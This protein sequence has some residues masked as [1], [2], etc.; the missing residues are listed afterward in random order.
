VLSV[1]LAAP[2]A[3]QAVSLPAKYRGKRI[4]GVKT[5]QKVVAFDFNDGPINANIEGS[6]LNLAQL[7]PW[8]PPSAALEVPFG[9]RLGFTVVASGQTRHPDLMASVDVVNPSYAGVQFDVLSV[10]IATVREGQIDVDTLVIKRGEQQI[11]VDG[12]LPFSWSLPRENGAASERRPGLIPTGQ[13]TLNGRI[14][15]TELAFFL[16]L[17][18]EYLRSRKPTA[19]SAPTAPFQWT[20]IEAKG[21]VDSSVSVTGT[22]KDPT[23]RGFL[24][25][26]DGSLKP[27]NWKHPLE[28]LGMDVALTGTGRDNLVEVRALKAAYD[29]TKAELAG[30]V[31]L[32]YLSAADFWRNRFDLTAK[33]TA[34]DQGMPGGLHLTNLTGGLAL[35]TKDG[36]QVVTA[37]G[38][39][40]GL[41]A[42]HAALTGSATLSDFRLAN[43]ANNQFDLALNVTPGRIVYANLVNAVV[44]GKLQ[45][46]TPEGHTKALLK[47]DWQ[48]SEGMI[49]LA[50]GG[51]A[52]AAKALSSRFPSPD[53]DITAG[54]GK[55]LVFRGSGTTAP[56]DPN[57]TAVRVAGT[58]QHPILSGNIMA[59]GGQTSLPTA[60]LRLSYLGV[61]Y[62]VEPVPGDRDD[63]VGLRTRGSVQ[64]LAETTINRKGDSPIRI[65]VNISGALP[66]QVVVQASSN[67]ALSETQI[68]ALLGGIPFAQLPGIGGRDANLT[69]MVSEQFLA[70]LANAFRLR[71]FQPIEEELKRAL[72]LSE[73]GITFAFDQPVSVQIGKYVLRNF[74]VSYERPLTSDVQRYDLRVSYELPGGLRISYHNDERND[75]RVEVGY[76]FTF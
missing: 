53:L 38:L 40:F 59:R 37:E 49:G 73:L 10:P 22:V 2:V 23:L 72:G 66:D 43:L 19:T 9:G 74:L 32:D 26:A 3:A 7:R 44:G 64:G 33:G 12:Q 52:G 31:S 27:A 61:N 46:V 15:Q 41:G 18:D 8:L 58:P 16:P 54:L 45:L 48:V 24:R 6:G 13:V 50:P 51:Q 29:Q 34:A 76:N 30:R 36:K 35:H 39:A 28:G 5:K 75:Q 25:V 17:V 57:P 69:Q 62:T 63:P 70:S 20:T 14:D 68:Y 55:S 47:G 60:T 42:A 1:L 56:L 67:P 11:I 71:V 65:S 21:K 4:E